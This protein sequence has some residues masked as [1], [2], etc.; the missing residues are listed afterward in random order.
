MIT[1]KDEMERD[2][3]F[4]GAWRLPCSA[5]SAIVLGVI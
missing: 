1:G 5:L 4:Y 2:V 3:D